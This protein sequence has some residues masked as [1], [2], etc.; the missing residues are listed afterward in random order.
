LVALNILIKKFQLE[1]RFQNEPDI[2]I[3]HELLIHDVLTELEKKL[4]VIL[5]ERGDEYFY[6]M[7]KQV[8]RAVE[9]ITRNELTALSY[10][11]DYNLELIGKVKFISEDKYPVTYYCFV[12]LPKI[13]DEGLVRE[14]HGMG[15]HIH[16]VVSEN[17]K[18]KRSNI[19]L[20]FN[21][22][23]IIKT[24]HTLYWEDHGSGLSRKPEKF[25]KRRRNAI[26]DTS[27]GFLSKVAK[28]QFRSPVNAA[29]ILWPQ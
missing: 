6:D 15:Y 7:D 17:K 29:G 26:Y 10:G 1:L 25:G 8:I 13:K 2:N 20:T 16:Y 9:S 28:N 21:P 14:N 3:N 24:Q 5:S 12:K 4:K 23:E 18:K 11:I 27:C 22:K 19:V